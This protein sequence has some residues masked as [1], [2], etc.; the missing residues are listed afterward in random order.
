MLCPE[1]E[2]FYVCVHGAHWSRIAPVRWVADAL[3]ITLR[4]LDLNWE[5][6]VE[7]ARNTAKTYKLHTTLEFLSTEFQVAVPSEILQALQSS[8]RDWLEKFDYFVGAYALPIIWDLLDKVSYF[9]NFNRLKR[10]P[11]GW[12]RFWQ[13]LRYRWNLDSNWALFWYIVKV[14]IE[15]T[16]LDLG[17]RPFFRRKAAPVPVMTDQD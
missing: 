5:I 2:L 15:R 8:H 10:G 1:D 9:L 13:Y 14:L 11:G 16:W 7:T 12:G 6:L 17:T 3:M 4:H